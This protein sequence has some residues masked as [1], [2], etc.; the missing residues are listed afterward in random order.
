MQG[1][2]CVGT[3]AA[4]VPIVESAVWVVQ[5]CRPVRARVLRLQA[6][7]LDRVMHAS[8]RYNPQTMKNAILL[9]P[10]K[11]DEVKPKPKA[12]AAGRK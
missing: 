8:H 4:G 9:H 1:S 10:V 6:L 5:Q 12:A 3:G 11:E 7:A 2:N